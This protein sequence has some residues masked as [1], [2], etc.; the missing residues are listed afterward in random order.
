MK[1]ARSKRFLQIHLTVLLVFL[2]MILFYKCPFSYFFRTACPGCGITRAHLAAL[3]FDFKTAFQY[4]PLFFTVAPIL[5]Y[6][7]HRNK[8]RKR[9]PSKVETVLYFLIIA[10]FVIVYIIKCIKQ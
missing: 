4:H 6:T 10:A 9:L 8:L 7:A 5:L 1:L 2:L 3:R